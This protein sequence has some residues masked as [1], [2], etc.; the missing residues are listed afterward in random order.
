MNPPLAHMGLLSE[1]DATVN[2]F[3]AA[4]NAH[5]LEQAPLFPSTFTLLLIVEV[6]P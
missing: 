6:P 1:A 5:V 2:P 4:Y 3:T